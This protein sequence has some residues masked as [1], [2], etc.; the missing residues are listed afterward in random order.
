VPVALSVVRSF[1]GE[2]AHFPFDYSRV[3]A[4]SSF[5]VDFIDDLVKEK[6]VV[7]VMPG[8]GEKIPVSISWTG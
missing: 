5:H 7:I 2:V 3:A 4:I 8:Q 6:L 1:K